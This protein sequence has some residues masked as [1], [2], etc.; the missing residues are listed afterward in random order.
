MHYDFS[1]IVTVLQAPD[2][3]ILPCQRGHPIFSK[4]YFELALFVQE[5]M[6]KLIGLDI[7]N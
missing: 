7:P 1:D 3:W 6:N 4:T 2:T 5:K